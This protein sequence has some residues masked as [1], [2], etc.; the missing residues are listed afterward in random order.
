[1]NDENYVVARRALA[2]PDEATSLLRGDCFGKNQDR[3]AAT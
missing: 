1:M 3:L 2:L